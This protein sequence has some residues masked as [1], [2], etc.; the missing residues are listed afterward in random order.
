MTKW[1]AMLALSLAPLAGSAAI[2]YQGDL[3]DGN[4]RNEELTNE[5]GWAQSNGGEVDFWSFEGTAGEQVSLLA[6]SSSTDIAFSLY[7]GTPDAFSQPFFFSND[8]D[9]DLFEFVTL[10]SS[11][12]GESL[13]DFILPAT[14]LFTLAIG[15][16]VPDFLA[17]GD[18][19]F[20]YSLQL[21]RQAV[22]VPLPG[23]GWLMLSGLTGLLVARRR[24]A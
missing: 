12:G 17:E 16:E 1:I 15:G 6:E 8:S 18:G 9:W 10:S 11:V 14:G 2:I 13:L 5:S 4:V 20:S 3:G 22:D 24:T 23:A 19:P 21:E 7:T